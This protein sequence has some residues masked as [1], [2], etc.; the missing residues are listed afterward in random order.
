VGLD[1]VS[2]YATVWLSADA[3][4]WSPQEALLIQACDAL[5][6][7]ARMCDALWSTLRGVFSDEQLLE[8]LVLAGYYRAIAYVVNNAGVTLED[9]ALRFPEKLASLA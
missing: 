3:T 2:L 6:R 4:C 9:A 7:G 5:H 1:S 8:V